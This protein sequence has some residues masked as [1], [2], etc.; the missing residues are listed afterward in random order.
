MVKETLT[1]IAL[2]LAPA[3]LIFTFIVANTKTAFVAEANQERL[4]SFESEVLKELRDMNTR[5]SRIEGRLN[6]E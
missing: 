4:S 6:D 2:I 5:L 1:T 3:N